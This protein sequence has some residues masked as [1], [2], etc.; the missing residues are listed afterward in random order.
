VLQVWMLR[1]KLAFEKLRALEL[2]E[3][4]RILCVSE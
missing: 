1:E 2:E 3:Q 4:V